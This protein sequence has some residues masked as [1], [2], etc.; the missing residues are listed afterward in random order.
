MKK[1]FLLDAY[2]LIYR[3][4]FAFI[5]NP[6]INSKKLNTSAPYGFFNTLM[7]VLKNQNPTHIAVAFDPKEKTFRHEMFEEYKANR[8]S[9]PEDMRESIPYVREIIEAFNIPIIE[10]PGYEADDVVGTLA[11]KAKQQ[12]FETYMMTPDKDYCQIVEDGIFL[13]KPRS[14][15]NAIDVM[16]VPEVCK[17]FEIERTE[18]V[19]DI[20][21]LWGDASDNIPGAPGI[22]EKTAKKLIAA[23]GSI[24]GI[25]ENINDLKGKQKENL[26]N[27]K[28]Q[29]LLSKELVTIKLDV[30]VEL[31]ED[32]LQLN[33]PNFA[34]LQE[35]FD[36]LEFSNAINRVKQLPYVNTTKESFGVKSTDGQLSLFDVED[37]PVQKETKNAETVDHEYICVQTEE[38]IN[39]L[40]QK[41]LNSKVVCFD[42][43]T[44]SLT[45]VEAEIVGIS[46]SIEKHK[47]YYIP[48][49]ELD[50][51]QSKELLHKFDEIFNSES[52][53]KVGQNLKY[54][55]SI[56][57]NYDILVKGPLFD[58]LIAHYLLEPEE[59]HGLDY[60][61]EVFLNYTPISIETLI[62]KKGKN[63]QNFLSVAVDKATEYA[64]EDADITYQLYDILKDKLKENKLEDLFNNIEMPLIP[65]LA[66][67]EY[68]GVAIN[69]DSLN[70]Y[71]QDLSESIVEVEKKIYEHAGFEF[72]IGSPKQLGEILFER[73]KITDK[74][75]KTKT[76]Q[77]ATG[78]DVL[79]KYKNDHPIIECIL[80]YRE[81]KKLLSTYV[82]ALPKLLSSKTNKIHTSYNQAVT[83]TGRLSSTNPNLQN[84]PIKTSKGRAIRKAFVPS[85]EEFTFLS[86]D[87]SQIELRVIAHFSKDKNFIEAFVNNLDVH[88]ATAAKIFNVSHEAVT[89]EQRRQA[90][91]ANFGIVY[92][93]SSFGLSQNLNISRSD[94][95]DLIDGYFAAYPDVKKFMDHSIAVARE[96][97]YVETLFGRKRHLKDINSQNGTVRGWA[98][99]NAINAPIQGTAADL[100]KMAMIEIYKE[101]Q[102]QQLRSKMIMQV[103]DELNFDVHR[104]EKDIVEKIVVEKMQNVYKLDV[105]LIVEYGFADNWLEAH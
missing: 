24:E 1:L 22:G 98:E 18:Q 34:K 10:A 49:N 50:Y 12:G 70:A 64:S 28:D 75:K 6:R 69:E 74:A 37:I 36:N 48:F 16:G 4:Y 79:M 63:Q 44:T 101:F 11:K 58:T 62:G 93:I 42:T 97:G 40:I 85:N 17:K 30:P 81:L 38:D 68:Y 25:Y 100:I 13:F 8:Q 55:I 35:L 54:D 102:K 67:M 83:A 3:S 65:V 91:S 61:S 5:K 60:L 32:D 46:F 23:Y 51:N 95:K 72:N 57:K 66:D 47:A 89:S 103:H 45:T 99:R 78:E 77:Y 104:D 20:L 82:D 7:D 26:L 39:K 41:L 87:Y 19:I 73:M 33:E 43:E 76:K 96:T 80:E 56:L 90:K 2:A 94:A 92:G 52:I 29:V 86:A 105:P 14:F 27:F 84:I 71:A 21:G 15:G 53:L 88:T 31:V 9:M 59:K